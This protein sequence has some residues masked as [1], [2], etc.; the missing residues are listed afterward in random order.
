MILMRSKMFGNGLG[1]AVHIRTTRVEIHSAAY[2]YISSMAM[3]I[4]R[5]TLEVSGEDGELIVNGE[6]C[7]AGDG[8]ATPSLGEYAIKT[9]SKGAQNR[10][11]IHDV[12]LG[13][14][15]KDKKIITIRSN[16][17][18]GLVF[19]D[20]KGRFDD[21]EGLLGARIDNQGKG[22]FL[23]RDGS[24]DMTGQWNSYGEEWQVQQGEAMLF[25]E[26]RAPQHPVA[27]LY[28][29]SSAVSSSVA[30]KKSR[31]RRRLLDEDGSSAAAAAVSLEAATGACDGSIGEK[32]QF[33]IDDVMAIGDLELA[34]DPFY[35]A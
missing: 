1:L 21:S 19:V 29:D 13:E 25:R 32:K 18:S 14:E 20:V 17:K 27:C 16:T 3:Q 4:G 34:E 9:S 11:I 26:A 35:S 8:K 10:I 22:G 30:N 2:S 24:M 7:E 23:S 12:I 31:L 15:E 28:Y 33:C 6:V 5:D